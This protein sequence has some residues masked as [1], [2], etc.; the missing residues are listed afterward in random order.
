MSAPTAS[1][2]QSVVVEFLVALAKPETFT[3]WFRRRIITMET[4]EGG[5]PVVDSDSVELRV[6]AD[7]LL[8]DKSK[9]KLQIY[10]HNLV[11][12]VISDGSA[13]EY[14]GILSVLP[15]VKQSV[16][17]ISF[18]LPEYLCFAGETEEVYEIFVPGLGFHY[19]SI[20][21]LDNDFMEVVYHHEGKFTQVFGSPAKILE[22]KSQQLQ[23][24]YKHTAAVLKSFFTIALA[25]PS[26]EDDVQHTTLRRSALR[27]AVAGLNKFADCHRRYVGIPWA[28]VPHY[29]FLSFPYGYIREFDL[30]GNLLVSEKYMMN[31]ATG[32]VGERRPYCNDPEGSRLRR[33]EASLQNEE[34]EETELNM[35]RKGEAYGGHGHDLAAIRLCVS[36]VEAV[37]RKWAKKKAVEFRNTT[38]EKAAISQLLGK[39]EE[40]WN[41]KKLIERP[42]EF[43]AG[44]RDAIRLR[45]AIEHKNLYPVDSTMVFPAID[46]LKTFFEIV[47]RA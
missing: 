35:L 30:A 37:L 25:I 20:C 14:R 15:S 41:R 27:F 2:S 42:N 19:R 11:K 44:I 45:H 47:E 43:M 16:A 12:M 13:A 18:P 1:V 31:P 32:V 22:F 46:K 29:S 33:F 26:V 36:A 39:F 4:P 21:R 34:D 10:T 6:V 9:H 5:V 38:P 40:S 28:S 7:S 3:Y 23:E 17:L 8:R 24:P